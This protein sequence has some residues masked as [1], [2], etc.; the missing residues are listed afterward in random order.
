MITANNAVSH[1]TALQKGPVT[2]ALAANAS[3][4]QLYKS[5]IISGTACGTVMDHAV[6]LVGY[7]SQN[8]QPYWII[9][10]SWGSSW[11]ESGYVRIAR[12][13]TGTDSGVCGLL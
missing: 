2:I 11:G 5:G 8:G 6:T 1:K 4:F 10:N 3:V 7:G 9:K 13:D 12:N